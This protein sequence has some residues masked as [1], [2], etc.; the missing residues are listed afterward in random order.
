MQSFSDIQDKALLAISE[1]TSLEVHRVIVGKKPFW[2][3]VLVG[4]C[5]Y[6]SISGLTG[7]PDT[8]GISKA[9]IENIVE[10]FNA[11]TGSIIDI[12]YE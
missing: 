7:D 4:Y 11:T 6:A 12:K 9:G 1:R 10:L 3:K 2:T 5:C 8:D